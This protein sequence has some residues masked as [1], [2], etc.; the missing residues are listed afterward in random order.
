MSL[1][2]FDLRNLRMWFAGATLALGGGILGGGCSSVDLSTIAGFCQAVATADC[3]Q[4]IVTACYGSSDQT[5][6]VDTGNCVAARSQITK[7]NPTGLPYHPELADACVAAHQSAFSSAQIDGMTYASVTTACLP[8]FNRGRSVGSACSA[9]SDCDVGGQLLCVLHAGKG[10][11]QIPV[12]ANGGESCS[13]AAAQCVDG[14]FC[15]GGNHCVAAGG[16]GD[17]CGGGHSC[18]SG[19]RCDAGSKLCQAQFPNTHECNDNADCAGGFCLGAGATSVGGTCAA[20]LTYA[21]GGSSC[22]PFLR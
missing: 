22:K 8:V 18:G 5:L 7:C 6:S 13:A 20:S 2:N 17:K 21:F 1:F 3:S 19:L 11:C 12:A 15:D 4:A 14:F 16:A 10:S 9:D